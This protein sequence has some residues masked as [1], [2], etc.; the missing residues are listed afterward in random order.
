M[1]I[2]RLVVGLIIG[3]LLVRDAQASKCV[4][5]TPARHFERADAVVVG[6]IEAVKPVDSRGYAMTAE[7]TV[8]RNWKGAL[9][10][11]VSV[12][13]E[14]TSAVEFEK[15]RRYLMYLKSVSAQDYATDRCSGTARL[16][17]SQRAL[18][19]LSR[20][21]K[22]AGSTV[23]HGNSVSADVPTH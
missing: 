22:R 1:P 18:R 9:S 8:E 6:F 11:R 19:W 20:E 14:G 12:L 13:T 17:A 21:A 15:G 4:P 3:V 7:V 2:L 10:D 23:V 16:E 5:M